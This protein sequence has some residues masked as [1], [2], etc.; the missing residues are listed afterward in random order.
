[1]W[2]WSLLDKSPV[3][4]IHSTGLRQIQRFGKGGTIT[5][6][7]GFG[8]SV[9]WR[10]CKIP[11]KIKYFGGKRVSQT[12]ISDMLL[13]RW[14]KAL[15]LFVL[16]MNVCLRTEVISIIPPRPH[17]LKLTLWASSRCNWQCCAEN[18]QRVITLGSWRRVEKFGIFTVFTTTRALY[19]WI[20]YSKRPPS[21]RKQ[22]CPKSLNSKLH[23]GTN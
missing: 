4:I 20:S 17:V 10:I 7:H 16:C 1:M 22:R 19:G 9:R 14:S 12:W 15:C 6:S 11:M 13:R 18:I 5:G 23:F 21:S 3:L 2:S 8:T